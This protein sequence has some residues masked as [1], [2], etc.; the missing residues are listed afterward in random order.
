MGRKYQSNEYWTTA[1]ELKF[2][3]KLGQHRR[4]PRAARGL[5]KKYLKAMDLRW[6]WL[7]MDP[8]VIRRHVKKLIASY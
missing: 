6:D 8:I 3:D 4:G 5:L 1:H 2:L 7:Y